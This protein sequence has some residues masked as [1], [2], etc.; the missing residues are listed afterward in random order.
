MASRLYVVIEC[1]AVRECAVA[2]P[3]ETAGFKEPPEMPP[4]AKPPTVTQEPIARPK[5][6]VV[7]V[8]SDTAAP[9]TTKHSTKV[10]TISATAASTKVWLPTGPRGKDVPL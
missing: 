3:K 8:F 10:N 1:A 9:I 2:M 6:C 7:F 4:M 5:N